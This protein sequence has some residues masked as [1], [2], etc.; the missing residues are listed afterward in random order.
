METWIGVFL[1]CW[2]SLGSVICFTMYNK[3]CSFCIFSH[4]KVNKILY[5]NVIITGMIKI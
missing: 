4:K 1:C 3:L 2:N 5:K